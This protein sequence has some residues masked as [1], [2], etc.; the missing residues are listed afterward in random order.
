[1]N[2]L[3][4]F[5]IVCGQAHTWSIGGQLLPVCQRCTG[6]YVGGMYALAAIMLLRPRPSRWCLWLNGAFLLLMIPFG[7][8]LVWQNSIIRTVTGQLF[9]A[10]LSYFLL[11]S[12]LELI[13]QRKFALTHSEWP[14]FA[15]VLGGIPLLLT[16]IKFG[17]KETAW[18]VSWSAF[19]G[20]VLYAMLWLANII[21]IPV[22]IW[23]TLGRR[24]LR[25]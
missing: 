25:A 9:G 6:L 8:H 23:L 17:G 10:G 4:V 14:Y 2:L 24:R 20:L 11:L 18:M 13:S 16:L 12:P 15:A 21:A 22:T 7:Y 19:A 5:S 3:N 1:M